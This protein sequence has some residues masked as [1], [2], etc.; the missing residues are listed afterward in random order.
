MAVTVLIRLLKTVWLTF[1]LPSKRP[2]S[3]LT[4]KFRSTEDAAEISFTSTMYSLCRFSIANCGCPMQKIFWM[5]KTTNSCLSC[6]SILP[7]RCYC[8]YEVLAR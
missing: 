8:S 5:M 2:R 7:F 4:N 3:S 1:C 6:S